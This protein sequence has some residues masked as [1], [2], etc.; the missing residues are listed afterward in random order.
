VAGVANI[1]TRRSVDETEVQA[2]TETPFDS[3]GELYRAGLITGLNF[4]KGAV[5]FSAQY[6][7]REKLTIGDRDFLGCPEDLA[8]DGSGNR[9]DREDRSI[10]ASEPYSG[11]QNLYANTVID[12]FITGGRLV[13]SADGS[14]VGTLPGYH[15]RANGR[16]DDPAGEAFYE[17]VLDFPFTQSETAINEMKRT[18]VY[19]T[20][21]YAFDFWGGVDWDMD[22]LYSKRET[23]AEGWRQF[24][25]I[26]S[27]TFFDPYPDDPT[28]DPSVFLPAGQPVMPYPSNTDVSVDYWYVTSGLEGVLPTEKYWSWEIYG[29]YSHSNGD[30]TRNSILTS[31]SGDWSRSASAPPSIDYYD[32][33]ILSGSNMQ[34]LIDAVGVVHTGNTVYEQ[35]QATGIL[36]G[37]LFELPA[38]TLSAA[39]GAE[40]RSFSIDDQ[41]SDFSKAGDLWGESS[42]IA[43]KGTNHVVEA[44]ME[45][46][47]PLLSGLPAVENMTLNLSARTFDYKDGGNDAV[48][49]AGLRWNLT[50]TFM[51]RGTRGTSYRAPALFELYLGNQTSF[52]NQTAV[53]ACIDWGESTNANI[54]TNCAADG[55]PSDYNGFPSTS[56]EI[57]AGGGVDNLKSETSDAYTIGMVWTPKFSNLSIALDYYDIE[58]NDQISQLGAGSIVAGCYVSEN[59]PNAF[60]DLFTRNP[61]NDVQFPFNIDTVR[62]TF[63]NINSQRVQ[64]LDLNLRW[65]QDFDFGDLTVE[66]QSTWTF[67]NIF[68]LF[69]PSLVQGFETD[70]VAGSVGSPENVT[71]LRVTLDRHDWAFNYYA[72]Y[73]ARTS[74][75]RYV[76]SRDSYFGFA[77]GRFDVSMDSVVYHNL[78]VVY[79]QD[80]WDLLVGINN[81]LDKEPDVVSDVF[82]SRRG[83]VP[84]SATQYDLLGR[85]AFV[86]FTW[87][88]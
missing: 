70:D 27:S 61:A 47:I 3:G 63:V 68:Q 37:D 82:R 73:V 44:F 31:K 24:F 69:D 75:Y 7:K 34:A 45:A 19:A 36:A 51:L 33:G 65:D 10:T 29:S 32:P 42:A 60:C 5:T 77:D 2:V 64:G 84:V 66:A 13:P 57:T 23:R 86:R 6:E 78:S 14:T 30:Y 53:D 9:I 11:C 46:E 25:P 1:I 38:G 83:N 49:K 15:P 62:D 55:I 85:R 4:E 8:F 58:V 40:Y 20:A 76:D 74:D 43:T 21:D 17:D 87:R 71:N 16:Y 26:I 80:K 67:E 52:S 18:N 54:R 12:F 35:F 88:M 41:P 39:F 50:P 48:W 72:Q 59:F 28:W 81:V 22:V 56:A 79:Q